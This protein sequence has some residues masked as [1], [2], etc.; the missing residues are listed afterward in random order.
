MTMTRYV[1]A[2]ILGFAIAAGSTAAVMNAQTA[3]GIKV[4]G[5]W[6]IDVRN[7]DGT[8]ASR[9]EFNNSLVPGGPL[10]GSG[11]IAGLLGRVHKTVHR[12]EIVLAGPIGQPGPCGG[13]CL[14][15]E[16]LSAGLP[17]VGELTVNV[18]LLP[19]TLIPSGAGTV[20]LVGLARATA[21]GSIGAVQTGVGV[22]PH[23]GC[24]GFVPFTQAFTRHQLAAPINV[25]ANQVVE[26]TVV[27]SFS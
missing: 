25:T 19:G 7:P 3:E 11:V 27:F 18:P 23:V 13:D 20:Q 22:C 26:V 1:Y 9:H 21:A 4:H 8:L 17:A 5:R 10:G 6:T 16:R 12:W 2:S 15:A 14:I 24:P